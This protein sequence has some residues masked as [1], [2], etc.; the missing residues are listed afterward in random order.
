M[1]YCG[2]GWLYES[3]TDFAVMPALIDSFLI[4]NYNNNERYA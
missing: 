2:Q 4:S 3:K 1:N